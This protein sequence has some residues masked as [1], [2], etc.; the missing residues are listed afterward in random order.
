LAAVLLCVTLCVLL[1]SGCDIL[2]DLGLLPE[3]DPGDTQG[4]GLSSS[5]LS[6]QAPEAGVTTT[7]LTLVF[8]P[9]I[10]GLNADDITVTSGYP[11]LEEITAEAVFP[12]GPP[13]VY[14]LTLSDVTAT[15][16]ITVEVHKDGYAI[17]SASRT[18]PVY[19]VDEVKS[20]TFVSVTANGTTNETTTQL[21][22][23]FSGSKPIVKAGDITVAGGSTGAVAG[24]L[25]N[26]EIIGGNSIYTLFLDG[27]TAPGTV[28][29]GV[30]KNGYS[31]SP[32]SQ[33][34]SVYYAP[35]AV[36]PSG[37]SIKE[38][39]E[40]FDL[41]PSADVAATFNALHEF[42]ADEGLTNSPDM[43]NLG[44]WID[45]DSLTV[46]AVS[47]AGGFSAENADIN[48][49]PPPF[50]GYVGKSLRLI[51]VGINSFNGTNG[52]NQQHVVFQFQNLPV[53]HRMNRGGNS[54]AAS[55]IREYLVPVEGRGG[56]FFNGLKTA[57]VPE[58]VLWAPTRHVANGGSGAT[59][60]DVI[61]DLLWLPTAREMFGTQSYSSTQETAQNQA[62]L[63]Y[64]RATDTAD[65]NRYRVKYT[66]TGT[67]SDY[68]E[69]SPYSG[70]STHF[71]TVSSSGSA[72]ANSASAALG[73]APAFCVK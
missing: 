48:P 30:K 57:G 69:G 60:I 53:T 16:N 44:D 36:T 1:L 73:I 66:G 20:G 37:S 31:F 41:D 58:G 23:T 25:T 33:N 4:G 34:V 3:D 46:E 18:V 64:Y 59:G 63:E 52:N 55:E 65:N 8:N 17:S 68:W 54:Y 42:I 22:L 21:T 14:S 32:P 27:V 50:E 12:A 24:T 70:N 6:V 56:N 43:I 39:L 2:K 38:A 28:T 61:T 49:S 15:G 40:A 62:R 13:G 47:G 51:V 35:V 26:P 10:A 29:V 11:G 7:V 72:Y 71:C 19:Y 67:V 5:V 45:L 9:D